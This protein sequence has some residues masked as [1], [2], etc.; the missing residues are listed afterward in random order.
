MSD[1]INPKHYQTSSGIEAIQVIE[2]YGLGFHCGN[3][4]KYLVRA[5][6][7][8]SDVVTDLEKAQW[9]ARRCIA[10]GVAGGPHAVVG[11]GR[12][13][14]W[15]RPEEIADAFGLDGYRR[16][17]VLDILEAAAW[18]DQAVR[19]RE[20]AAQIDNALRHARWV[21]LPKHHAA[22]A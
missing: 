12:G 2:E 17:A 11:E 1:Q 15:R 7:K 22:S 14:E 8:S 16:E 9:Y 3:A 5:G 10:D 6:K 13:F 21:A 4:F 20:A 18:G 19:L